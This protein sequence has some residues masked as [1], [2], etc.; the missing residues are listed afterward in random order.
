MVKTFEKRICK[1]CSNEFE[2]HHQNQEYCKNPHPFKCFICGKEEFK[3]GRKLF[4]QGSKAVCKNPDCLKEKI[5][6]SNLEK[7]GVEHHTKVKD[8]KVTPPKNEYFTCSGCGETLK[9]ETP[10]QKNCK[11]E[12]IVTKKC[13]Y[14]NK[15]FTYIKLCGIV[16]KKIPKAC[17]KKCSRLLAAK[18]S[19]ETFI[20]RYGVDNI[21]KTNDFKEFMRETTYFKTDEFKEKM[22]KKNLEK[23]GVEFHTQAKVVKEKIKETCI[24]K[25]GATTFLKSDDYK[26]QM[27]NRPLTEAEKRYKEELRNRGKTLEGLKKYNPWIKHPEEYFDFENYIKSISGEKTVYELAEYFNV[28]T[29]TIKWKAEQ[30]N[31]AKDIK[32]FNK[33][34]IVEEEFK[35]KLESNNIN[36]IYRDRTQIYPLELD[37]FLSEYNIAVELSPTWT[38]SFANERNGL[39]TNIDYHYNKFK[40]CE[41][42]GIKLITIFD[43]IE[44][45]KAIDYIKSIIKKKSNVNKFEINITSEF[46]NK[47]KKFLNNYF[48]LNSNYNEN[49]KIIEVVQ[50][51]KLIALSLILNNNNEIELKLLVCKSEFKPDNFIKEIAEFIFNYYPNANN[52]IVYSNNNFENGDIYKNNNFDLIEENQGNIIWSNPHKNKYIKNS[53]LEKESLDLLLSNF[54]NYILVNR[55]LNLQEKEELLKK[56]GFLPVIDCGYRKW[57]YKTKK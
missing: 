51:K 57:L 35:S 39:R 14:C 38:H 27:K 16:P 52:I 43:W 6:R 13:E 33:G 22:K 37:F 44:I 50:N 5:K 20:E 26:K 32:D 56:Y 55:T 4:H 12:I 11:K 21:S 17:S 40:L 15:D 30:S 54:P 24:D 34:S 18:K 8:F 47:H 10:F 3:D 36:Y 48:I 7:Y 28:N 46:S 45:D 31:V 25:Y 42:K 41:E 2:P 1:I 53:L 29:V 23:Y 49:M 19:K 9:K